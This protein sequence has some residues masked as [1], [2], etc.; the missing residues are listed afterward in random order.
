MTPTGEEQKC[1]KCV[2]CHVLKWG[3]VFWLN[4]YTL[5]CAFI[6]TTIWH[7]NVDPFSEPYKKDMKSKLVDVLTWQK[8]QEWLYNTIRFITIM[9]MIASPSSF[10]LG[11]TFILLSVLY[12]IMIV[13]LVLRQTVTN[14]SIYH[15]GYW[16][17]I[18]ARKWGAYCPA[19]PAYSV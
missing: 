17:L 10:L 7:L 8:D 9:I 12:I 19:F 3:C 14:Q 11:F 1:Q 5:G 15:C 13:V 2:R 18:V 6:I 16:L 4:I